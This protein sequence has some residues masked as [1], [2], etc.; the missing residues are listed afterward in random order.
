MVA[1]ILRQTRLIV[2]QYLVVLV[3]DVQF[4]RIDISDFEV[5]FGVVGKD[6]GSSVAEGS[7]I[8]PVMIDTDFEGNLL[9]TRKAGIVVGN[10]V[11]N[12]E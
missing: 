6:D 12:S 5:N 1:E 2:G 11:F 10:K 9:A 3:K 4:D 7:A 8:N